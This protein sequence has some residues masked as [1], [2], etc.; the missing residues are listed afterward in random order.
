MFQI[1]KKRLRLQ[2]EEER[3]GKTCFRKTRKDSACKKKKK[4]KERHVSERLRMQKVKEMKGNAC[5]QNT[6]KYSLST[7]NSY[8]MYVMTPMLQRS[9]LREMGS[10]L[11]TSGDTNSGVP[12]ISRTCKKQPMVQSTKYVL[13]CLSPRRNWDSPTPSLPSECA[14]PPGT[15]GGGGHTRLRV[16]GWGSPNSYDW[17]KAQHSACSVVQIKS[18]SFVFPK[19]IL[20]YQQLL[21]K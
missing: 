18:P 1:D 16:R 19:I 17:R 20:S 6:I 8:M 2:K 15:K 13:Q 12:S 4:R 9:V 3:K 10:Q 5:L 21:Q 7:R 11:T 14:P